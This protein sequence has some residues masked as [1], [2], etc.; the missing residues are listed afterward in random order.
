[1][2]FSFLADQPLQQSCIDLIKASSTQFIQTADDAFWCQSPTVPQELPAGVLYQTERNWRDNP[3]KLI[4]FDMDS[5]LIRAECIDEMARTYGV[6][7]EVAQT[8]ERAMRGELD[9]NGS[10]LTRLG[11]LKG[12]PIEQM[13]S[14]YDRIEYQWG[15]DQLFKTL[16]DMGI[17]TAVLSG[18]FTWFAE[19]VA[20]RLN[21]D[22]IKANVLAI[23]DD[24]LTGAV[25]GDIVNAQVKADTLVQLADEY[26]IDLTDTIAVGD[27]A[28]DLTMMGVAGLGVAIHGKPAVVEQAETAI[29]VGGIDRLLQLIGVVAK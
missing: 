1:M 2:Y 13:L 10:L 28:N 11:L 14:V 21:I 16:S 7:D 22:H 12:M 4:A 6:Y 5:T 15:A 23:E 9:F 19:R 24:Q 29:N 20:K 8:T 26:Q 3:P 25:V 18:G 27:G 17:K